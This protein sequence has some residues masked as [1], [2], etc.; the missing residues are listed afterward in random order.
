MSNLPRKPVL[1]VLCAL[2]GLGCQYYFEVTE[3]AKGTPWRVPHPPP[4]QKFCYSPFGFK[5]ISPLRLYRWSKPTSLFLLPKSRSNLS[6]IYPNKIICVL[7]CLDRRENKKYCVT[8]N[9]VF[10]F[11]KT[12]KHF[13][14]RKEV[15]DVVHTAIE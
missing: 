8:K 9:F 4:K 5:K 10:Y 1:D 14:L 6:A 7:V 12:C 11:W 15:I 3:D 13:S 2:E